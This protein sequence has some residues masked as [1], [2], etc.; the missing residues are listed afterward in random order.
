MV[1]TAYAPPQEDRREVDM[2]ANRAIM[3]AVFLALDDEI[4]G[5]EKGGKSHG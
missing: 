5:K 2:N 4:D 1:T 3:N